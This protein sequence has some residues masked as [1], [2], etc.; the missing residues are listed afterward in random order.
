MVQIFL[1][2]AKEDKAKVFELYDRLKRRGYI[3]WL[4]IKD[5]LG[6]QLWDD[7]IKK[8]I[9]N[10]DVFLACL[11]KRSV[12]KQGYVQKEFRMALQK[13]GEIPRDKIYLIP[14]R[15]DACE[16]PDLRQHEYGIKIKDYQW[17]DYFE[18][19]GFEQLVK[20]IDYHFPNEITASNVPK[21]QTLTFETVKV[22]DAG[23]ITSREQR[24]AES[25]RQELGSGAYLDM[26]QIPGGLFWM[27][28]S[29]DEADR[30]DNEGPQHKVTVPTF[31]MSKYSITQRQWYAVSLLPDVD[32]HLEPH[33]SH[34][35]GENRPVEQV[36]WYEAVE[37]CKRLSRKTGK[38]YRLPS[39]AEWEFA[40][41]AETY[42]FGEIIST[43]YANYND[44]Y[45]YGNGQQRIYRGVTPPVDVGS[46]SPNA[47]GLYDM[48]GNVWEWCQDYRHD[49]Y[50]GA[51]SDGS[52]WITDGDSDWRVIRGCSWD[53]NRENVRSARRF[54]SKPGDRASNIGFRVACGTPRSLLQ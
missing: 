40:C 50:Y 52:A 35:K 49:H 8:A 12:D 36:S 27:G 54:N 39:E 23:S 32:R 11:S 14:L 20:S 16:I 28:S 25:F 33:P 21:L 51:P 6:G 26:V 18:E 41:R 17:I 31:Y 29:N 44:K 37:F 45:A 13:C 47:F 1:A 30:F 22:N 9:D 19:D 4:N 2:H 43:E 15:L 53:Y 5:L 38:S 3:P 42:F 7:Q 10:S 34:S 46:Y 48:H 24:S